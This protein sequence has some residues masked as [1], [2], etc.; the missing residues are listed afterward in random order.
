[1]GYMGFSRLEQKEGVEGTQCGSTMAEKTS[2]FCRLREMRWRE[3]RCFPN[4]PG[5]NALKVDLGRTRQ[6]GGANGMDQAKNG[7]RAK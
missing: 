5:A 6:K 3:I 7:G 1:M 4:A 2:A